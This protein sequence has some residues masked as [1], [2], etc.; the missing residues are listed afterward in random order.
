MRSRLADERPGAI[1]RVARE[2]GAHRH[3]AAFGAVYYAPGRLA[4][5]F[6]F[7]S[8]ASPKSGRSFFG[9]AYRIDAIP[10][11]AAAAGVR[12]SKWLVRT[13]VANLTLRSSKSPS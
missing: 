9:I 5:A 2:I 13:F 4:C 11:A 6:E 1:F 7:E 10:G 3:F 12:Y 8:D